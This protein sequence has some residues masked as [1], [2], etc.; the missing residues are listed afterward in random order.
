MAT[1][2]SISLLSHAGASTPRRPQVPGERRVGRSP[3]RRA[4]LGAEGRG[5]GRG[6]D[7]V[8]ERNAGAGLSPHEA[9]AQESQWLPWD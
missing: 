4:G 7:L 1:A 6:A 2:H 9:G 5:P 3:R 8:S